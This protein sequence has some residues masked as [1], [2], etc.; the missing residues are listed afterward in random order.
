MRPFGL[1][2]WWRISFVSIHASVK[3]ATEGTIV[4]FGGDDVSIH[5]SVKDATI[6]TGVSAVTL[7]GFNPRICKRCD[8]ALPMLKRSRK[9]SIHASVKD[10]TRFWR[11]PAP[12][13]PFQSTHL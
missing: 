6:A 1:W 7:P 3:D 10:A 5:A 4:G 2:Y 13:E 9:V 12:I 11:L 8:K